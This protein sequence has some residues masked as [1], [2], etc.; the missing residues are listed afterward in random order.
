MIP[1]FKV[2]YR[3]S[4]LIKAFFIQESS[5]FWRNHLVQQIGSLVGS[6]KILLS[7]SCRNSIYQILKILPQSKVIIPAYTC[8]V[9]AQAAIMAGKRLIFAHISPDT[10][11]VDSYP[12]IDNDSIVIVT[13]QFGN[14]VK[15]IEMLIQMCNAKSAPVIE[16]CAG[17]L[18]T[19]ING[20][21][22][23]TIGDFGVFSFSASKTIQSV[24]RGSFIVVK[25]GTNYNRLKSSMDTSKEYSSQFKY[26]QLI[27]GL[28]FNLNSSPIICGIF[29]V[30]KG[31]KSRHSTTHELMSNQDFSYCRDMYEWQ[32][33]IL[34]EQFER[35]DS[36]LSERSNM[37]SKY[38]KR[39]DNPYVKKPDFPQN[40]NYIRYPVLIEQRGNFIDYCHKNGIQ[41][42]MG[43]SDP[44][45]PSDFTTEQTINKDIVYL[46]IGSGYSEKEIQKII[47]T[48]NE[49]TN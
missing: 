47:K 24:T 25:D 35:L 34:S 43:Y 32:A 42:G 10:F 30:I 20:R 23:G 31:N 8:E 17:S 4:E 44:V 38:Q 18:G 7:S 6:E 46:P 14:P 48:I 36:I 11:N 28:L 16:D 33:Y 19:F 45:I 15:N 12:E 49:Y 41:V 3:I 22:T 39:I 13:H 29:A 9:V 26:K 2:N 5:S 27:K 21:H 1:V 37:F 40:A